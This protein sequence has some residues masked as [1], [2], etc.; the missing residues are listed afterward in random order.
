MR[1]VR[2]A[3]WLLI[4]AAAVTALGVFMPVIEAPLGGRVMSKRETL[5]L[6]GAASN[7]KLVRRLLAAYHGSH[8]T[9]V[10][11]TVLGKVMP[12]AGRAK[13]YLGD[14]SDAMDTLSGITDDDIKQAGTALLALTWIVLGLCGLTIA[15]VFFDAVNARYRRGRVIGALLL[16][17]I[18]AA[19]AI[20]VRIGCGLV[21]FEANDEV[22]S[23][24]TSLGYGATLMPIA[25]I[26]VVGAA[27]ALLVMLVRTPARA[28]VAA[29]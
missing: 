13:E 19:I 2:L 7:R 23:S 25:A 5:S 20:A 16:A 21:V 8:A 14:A 11:G 10:G 17:V 18:V 15:M 1:G 22:G 27:I 12:H 29:A 4:V 24:L 6:R 28:S 26:V 9:K 3:S